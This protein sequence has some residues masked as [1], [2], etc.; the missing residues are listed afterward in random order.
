MS[1]CVQ[2]LR[3]LVEEQIHLLKKEKYF[4]NSDW[5]YLEENFRIENPYL[6]TMIYGEQNVSDSNNEC[7]KC[8]RQLTKDLT[9]A[10]YDDLVEEIRNRVINIQK[11]TMN[12]NDWR[13]HWRVLEKFLET[14]SRL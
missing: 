12:E 13:R 9:E 1:Q 5:I 6:S 10:Q 14:I 11:V 7:S 3:T 2:S 8:H 4:S